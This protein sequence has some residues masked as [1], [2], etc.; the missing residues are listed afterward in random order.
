MCWHDGA[1]YGIY[2]SY[3]RRQ[4]TAQGAK[5][6]M[7][8]ANKL[9]VSFGGEPLFRN[10]TFTINP[11]DRVGLVGANGAGKTTLMRVLI[12]EQTAAEGGVIKR[13]SSVVSYLPQE[14]VV[15]SQTTVHEE[16]MKA[17][18]ELTTMEKRIAELSQEVSRRHGEEGDEYRDLLDELGELQHRFEAMNGFAAKGEVDKILM[19]LGFQPK[20][21]NRPCS[22]FSGGWQ[23]RIELAKLLLCEP[24]LLMLDEPTNHLDIESL[25]WIENFLRTYHGGI[26]LISHDR[27]FLDA[28]TTHTYEL[29]N[30]HLTVYTGNYSTF[31]S[32]R[33]KRRELQR[34]AH[35]NQQKM[36]A[37]TERFIKRF[38]YKNTKAAQVQSRIKMLEKLEW[39]KL[40]E[41]DES[42]IYFRFPSA[43]RSGRVVVELK[44]VT[45]R[46]DDNL[47]LNDVDFALERGEKVAFLGRNGEGKSTLS[48]IIAGAESFDGQRILGYNVEIGYFAQHQA[49]E[50]DPRLTVLDT[51]DAVAVGDIRTQLRSL[52]GAF[53]F[54][55]DDV[56]K[57]VS[58]LSG[59]EKSRLALAKLLLQPRNVLILDEP[60]NHLDMASKNVLKRALQ[61]FEGA[62]ILV[63]HDRD[64]LR[65]LIDKC[66]DFRNRKIKEYI[67]GIDD[68]LR[69]HGS[70]TVEDAF[71]PRSAPS[72]TPTA[73]G[74][75][76][77]SAASRKERKRREAEMRNKRYAAT[78]DLK[79]KLETIER[80]VEKLEEEK[81]ES[82]SLL[83]DPKIYA[84]GERSAEVQKRMEEI[85]AKLSDL[86]SRWERVAADL[87]TV[88]AEFEQ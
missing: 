76:T 57:P 8:T 83:A 41:A 87:E 88:Q 58:V 44:N 50:L 11:G 77:D 29:T 82:E 12:G 3:Y 39:I 62:I 4:L 14:G 51:V 56:F 75:G 73:K 15:L 40:P 74:N 33:E 55:G 37:D 18:G 6:T 25:T 79:G 42:E 27:A 21:L 68:Y 61:E 45:K 67:G 1:K 16:V 9:G 24:D 23:M 72:E 31:A 65:G 26:L 81:I 20:D 49:E 10:V 35:E 80:S 60:T 17:F 36:I 63:S 66:I 54:H 7:I 64:F 43:P 70:E 86:Y 13:P 38:R 84:D 85:Q 47:V 53:L 28:L 48:R 71:G 19:G 2:S 69:R 52:L 78:K 30:K 32:E 59:G 5:L 46:Y 34:A 22:E